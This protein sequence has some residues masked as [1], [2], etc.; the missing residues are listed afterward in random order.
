MSIEKLHSWISE[1][2]GSEWFAYVKRLSAND[3]GATGGHG[4]GIYIPSI[5]TEKAF[6]SLMNKHDHNPDHFFPGQID[7]HDLEVQELR[8]IYYNSKFSE[9]KKN[10]RD[11]QRIT[12]WKQGVD[13]APLQDPENTGALMIITFKAET[14]GL[15]IKHMPIWVCKNI[16]EEEYIESLIGEVLPSVTLFKPIDELFG[17]LAQLPDYQ[18]IDLKLPEEWSITFPSGQ[19]IIDFVVDNFQ[20]DG[21]E[22]DERLLN[23]RDKEYIIFRMVEDLHALPLIEKGFDS[24]E[25]FVALANSISNRRKSRAGRS[26]EIHLESIFVEEGLT[27]FETQAKTEGNKKPDFL[28]PSLAD[29]QSAEFSDDKLNMLA[30]KTTLKDRWRQ[31]LNEANRIKKKYLFTLQ[32]GVSE[33]QMKEISEE[34]VTLVAPK[35]L[36]KKFPK[37]YQ[38]NILTLQ[39]FIKEMKSTYNLN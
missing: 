32:E 34:G 7:S 28:F 14:S 9:K 8:A 21:I 37:A 5:F 26:L 2:S 22:P 29:Y 23:R 24:V 4:S 6:P 25:D 36:K 19:T 10:G 31:I 15:E 20:F 27:T 17:G 18:H 33:N 3:T 39:D 13:Y 38:D 1:K 11:E 35:A 30:V 12:R 16:E